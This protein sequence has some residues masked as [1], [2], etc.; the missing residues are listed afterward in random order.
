VDDGL[1]LPDLGVPQKMAGR[2]PQDGFAPDMTVLFGGSTPAAY[3]APR[4]NDQGGNRKT[5]EK[6]FLIQ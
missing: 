4:R 2:Y 6:L 1:H 5:H 3:A